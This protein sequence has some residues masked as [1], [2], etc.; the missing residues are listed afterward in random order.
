MY[1]STIEL[2]LS[3]SVRFSGYGSPLFGQLADRSL[4]LTQESPAVIENSVYKAGQSADMLNASLHL[5]LTKLSNR[6]IDWAVN[7]NTPCLTL[8]FSLWSSNAARKNLTKEGTFGYPP[9]YIWYVSQQCRTVNPVT[10]LHIM[11][12]DKSQTSF[13]L[14]TGHPMRWHC[15]SLWEG[16]YEKLAILNYGIPC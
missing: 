13:H 4:V 10:A 1:Q 11:R 3:Y 6:C 2:D 14:I 9:N 15:L 8:P 7:S 5:K 16:F 12:T